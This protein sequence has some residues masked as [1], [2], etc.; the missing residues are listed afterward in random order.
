MNKWEYKVITR[1][2]HI[3]FFSD[4]EWNIKVADFLH[5]MGEECWELVNVVPISSDYGE[6]RAGYTTHEKWIF[7]RPKD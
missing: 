4:G 2:R 7:K 3:G 1:E 6:H 5:Q